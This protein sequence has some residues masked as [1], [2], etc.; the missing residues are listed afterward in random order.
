MLRSSVDARHEAVLVHGVHD[1]LAPR[2]DVLVGAVVP[3]EGEDG[4][5]AVVAKHGAVARGYKERGK[6]VIFAYS[7]TVPFKKETVFRIVIKC[8]KK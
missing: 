8:S 7:K 1:A 5:A 2:L 4:V 3:E 6:L